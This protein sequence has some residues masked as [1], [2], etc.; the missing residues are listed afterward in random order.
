MLNVAICDDQPTDLHKISALLQEY[1][2]IHSIAAKVRAFSHPDEMLQVSAKN[3]FHM[4]L[5]DIV[6]PMVD[7]IEVGREL[8]RYDKTAQII[9]ATSE[10]GFA[11]EAFSANPVNYLLKPVD[12]EKLFDTLTLALS[13]LGTD[14]E[15]TIT[16]KAK[17]GY[18]TLSLGHIVSCEYN[19]HVASYS[20]RSGETVRTAYLSESFA[21]HIA[22][23]LENGQ[24]VQT[25]AAYAVNV[26]CISQLTRTGIKLVNGSIAPVSRSQ[27]NA[28]QEAYLAYR[29]G[30]ETHD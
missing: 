6:M 1:I 14:A 3:P 4:Y 24:C 13:R 19:N 17:G 5:L 26:A 2:Q 18:H 27:Y 29:L 9:Y 23:L 22:P 20:L 15:K 12:R 16:I 10:P 8:R 7:G 28:V 11:L 30:G 25:H 21:R